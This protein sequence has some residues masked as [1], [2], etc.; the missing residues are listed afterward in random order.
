MNTQPPL[1]AERLLRWYCHPTFLEEIE[2]DVYEL[3]DRRVEAKG[4]RVARLRFVWDVLRFCRMSNMKTSRSKR[5]V[6]S[7]VTLFSNYLKTGLR[8]MQRNLVSS[9]INIIGLSVAI[10]F[11]IS[12]FVF[13]EMQLS[14]DTF[15]TKGD[16]IYQITNY[17]DQDGSTDLWSDSPI[18]LGPALKRD[19]PS[20]EAFARVDFR[21]ATVRHGNRVFDE[22]T[23]L[24]DP[25]FFEMF[26]FG[27]LYGDK[28]ALY[29]KNQVI[30]SH[31]MASKYFNDD[32]PV[33]KV[34]SIKF[35]N[36]LMKHLTV[37]GV[38]EPFPYNSGINFDF[39]IPFEHF[40]DIQ[41]GRIN[42]W[43]YM[44]DGTFVLMKE[45]ENIADL[46]ES[47]PS[48]VTLQNESD[49]EWKVLS[50][51]PFVLADLSTNAYRIISS[52][53]GGGHPAGMIVLVSMAIFLLGMACFNFMNISVVSSSRR[54]KEIALRKV[55]G[56][57]R[58]EIIKQFLTENLL[59][60]FFAL[61]TGAL[62][63]YFL[64]VPWLDQMLAETD[65]QFRTTQPERL[66]LFLVLLLLFVAIVSGAYPAL[67]VSKF[68]TITIFKG[69]LRFG[70]KNLFSKVM[71]GIQFFLSVITIVACLVFVDQG[72]YMKDKEWGYE[73]E[74]TVSI[75]VSNKEQYHLL[76]NEVADHPAVQTVTASDYLIG[77]RVGYSSLEIENRQLPVHRIKVKDHYEKV[78]GLTLLEGSFISEKTSDQF[79]GVVIN[80]KFVDAMGWEGSAVGKSFV[81]DRA[82]KTVVG[83]VQNFHY[84]DFY[85]EVGPFLFEGVQ[86]GQVH[87]L[88][89]KTDAVQL[90]KLEEFV[91]G[92]WKKVAP[93]DPYDRIYQEDVFDNFYRENKSHLS[94][95][96]LIT[97]MAITLAC[98]GLYGL[99]SFNVEGKLKEY[100]VRK[101]LGAQPSVIVKIISK[102][103]AW[104]LLISFALGA[105]LGA[106]GMMNLVSS[107][108]PESKPVTV[109]PFVIAISIIALTLMITVAGQI[110]K[111]ISVNPADLLRNE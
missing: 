38:L 39:F 11:A 75:F 99:L 53:F 43:A 23:L 51:H 36:G 72:F 108:F 67:Y 44:T 98:L 90:A 69:S 64:L 16:R 50:L 76:K 2:G 80:E 56:S 15:H 32:E 10:C 85:A 110:R 94:I 92:I 77:R 61:G 89:I 18:T 87:Y 71:L 27:F 96:F 52:V 19:H 4:A 63:A 33:G 42:D 86:D 41:P 3:F 74:G 68:D 88:T 17:V 5:N 62:L 34:L 78:F 57:Q 83:V 48:Y 84:D 95:T 14:M 91:Q 35:N 26:D 59:Q 21:S 1:W 40:N 101:V 54:L 49:P 31:D 12:I 58:K 104:V 60:C 20:V 45:G 105:P 7:Q 29:T 82:K 22:F 24:V 25:A 55:M 97:G 111:A 79:S 47:F 109:F 6:M 100:S 65:L 103:Y 66:V 28:T 93:D 73:A 8:T 13:T 37:G 106:I 102:Q 46:T 70:S 107:I 9:T 30:I 81:L